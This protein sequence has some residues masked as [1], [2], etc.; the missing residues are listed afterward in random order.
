MKTEA[1]LLKEAMEQGLTDGDG[2]A[3]VARVEDLKFEEVDDGDGE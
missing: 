1:D 3:D 2:P